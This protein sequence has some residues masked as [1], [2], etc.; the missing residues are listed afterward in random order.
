[1]RSLAGPSWR[2]CPNIATIP[3]EGSVVEQRVKRL[4]YSRRRAL[5][6]GR[7]DCSGYMIIRFRGGPETFVAVRRRIRSPLAF[8]I[9]SLAMSASWSPL[10]TSDLSPP[11][12]GLIASST[13]VKKGSWYL[14]VRHPSFDLAGRWRAS[15]FGGDMDI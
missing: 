15:P 7:I 1:M 12:T 2:G 8:E 10:I 9:Q 4:R 3:H 6:Y 5:G 13:S 11:L 14:H